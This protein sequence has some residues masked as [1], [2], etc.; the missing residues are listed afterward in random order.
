MFEA[1]AFA[2]MLH[3]RLSLQEQRVVS[4]HARITFSLISLFHHYYILVKSFLML[5]ADIDQVQWG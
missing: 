1:L 3:I 5:V 4:H 2:F